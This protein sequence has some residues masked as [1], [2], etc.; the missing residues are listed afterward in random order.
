MFLRTTGEKRYDPSNVRLSVLFDAYVNMGAY[1]GTELALPAKGALG[2]VDISAGLGLTRNVYP[3]GTDYTP[4][5][6]YDGESE[7]NSGMLFSLGIPFRYRFDVKGS[8]KITYGSLSWQIPYYSDPYVDRDFMRRTEA[9]D[10]LSMIREG[11]SSSD[12][13]EDTYLNSYEWKISGALNPPKTGLDPYLS[14]FSIS[15][16]SSSLLFNQRYSRSYSGPS[17]PPNPGRAFFFPSRFTMFSVSAALAGT[18]FKTGDSKEEKEETKTDSPPGDALLPDLPISPWETIE[19]EEDAVRA[20]SD[21]YTFTP[22]ALGQK[23]TFASPGGVQFSVDYRL[24]PTTAS[25]LQFRTSEANWRDPEDINWGEVATIISRVRSDGNLDFKINP[26]G[27]SFYSGTLGFAGTGSWQD[28][29]YI[30]G[31]AEEF[32]SYDA[33]KSARDRAYNET[34]LT[35]SWD[36]TN[37]FRPFYQSSVWGA[38]NLQHTIK[39]LLAKTEVDTTGSNPVW[40]WVFATW[41]KTDIETHQVSANL[42][43]KVM[44]YNQN[45]S[46]S[47]VL[48]PKDQLVSG[49]AAFRAWIT[50]TSVR[51]RVLFPL[52]EEERKIE[53][54]YFT[55][56]FRF[57]P[58]S[59]FQQYVVYDPELSEY[60]TFTSS[61]S[62][63]G[64][65]ASYSA[66]Y[67]QPY[68]YNHNG[69]V[70]NSQPNGWIQM[71]EKGLFPNELRFGYSNTFAQSNLWDKRLSFSLNLN[72]NLSFDLQRYTNTKLGFVLGLKMGINGFLDL[73]LSTNAENVVMF[74]YFQGLPFF[75][76]P[77]QLYPGEEI[78]FFVDLLNSFRFDNIDLRRKSGFKMKAL[79][80]SLIHHLGDWNATLSMNMTPYLPAG[81]TSYT[82]SNEISFLI[83]WV[84]IGEIKT[85]ID[86]V[87]EILTVK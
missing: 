22:P 31:G 33:V 55:E 42:A 58:K 59:S 56:T 40:D 53:P 44:D 27:G 34:F 17:S 13:T 18:P 24:T 52:D 75:N 64:F 37:T 82:F 46:V 43:A 68:E 11:V 12:V 26:S 83:Q 1:L 15:S 47:A 48:P 76:L 87:K 3:S 4:F 60:T 8:F 49:S 23:F 36:F 57:N 63:Y 81:S 51:G 16:M 20:L 39:G 67:A 73:S 5:P 38:T 29:V 54:V 19:D 66:L 61:F 72:T 84:P 28:Y 62:F 10:W 77:V 25:E 69:S 32:S 65:T 78:N 85:Q 79:D 70:D 50:E 2:E 86:Y 35:S 30:N 21:I 80:L 14:T 9:L 45:L 41:E 7:W 74:K 71:S 6:R